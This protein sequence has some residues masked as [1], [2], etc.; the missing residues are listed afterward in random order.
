MVRFKLFY[1]NSDS[2]T[3]L[4]S[5]VYHFYYADTI[6]PILRG[7]N[8]SGYLEAY[9]STDAVR[10]NKYSNI[11]EDNVQGEVNFRFHNSYISK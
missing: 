11:I 6:R 1:F 2:I 3:I 4:K 10:K 5:G 8:T 9:N 7:N